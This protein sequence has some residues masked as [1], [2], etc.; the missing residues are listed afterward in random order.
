MGAPVWL[1]LAHKR[2]SPPPNPTSPVITPI[3]LRNRCGTS[4]NTAP[5]PTPR[6]PTT[7]TNNATAVADWLLGQGERFVYGASQFEL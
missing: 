3:S 5:L 7:A 1:S 2:P 6:V 4:W